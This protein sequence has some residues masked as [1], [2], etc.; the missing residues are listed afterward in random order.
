MVAQNCIVK[1]KLI[2]F[3]DYIGAIFNLPI[4]TFI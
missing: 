4:L 3:P 1:L 2:V